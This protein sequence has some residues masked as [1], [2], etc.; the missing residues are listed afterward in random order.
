MP[1]PAASLDRR[2]IAAARKAATPAAIVG[3]AGVVTLLLGAFGVLERGD[4]WLYDLRMHGVPNRD[5]SDR[6]LPIPVDD[7]STDHLGRWP[8][9]RAVTA[10]LARDAAKDGA[11]AV[12]LDITYNDVT[13]PEQDREFVETIAGVGAAVAAVSA[14]E[15]SPNGAMMEGLSE[16][17][18]AALKAF[19]EKV[20]VEI[21]GAAEA[22]PDALIVRTISPPIAEFLERGPG[23]ALAS[24]TSDSDG[25]LRRYAL[26]RRDESPNSP[27]AKTRWIPSLSLAI[28]C[29]WYG[30]AP[31]ALR[32]EKGALILPGARA[33]GDAAPH[34]VRIPVDSAAAMRVNFATPGVIASRFVNFREMQR[35]LAA[36]DGR[37]RPKV[38]DKIL[39]VY[40]TFTGSGDFH[41][42]P[43]A[44]SYP[45]GLINAE[46]VNT[47]LGAHWVLVPPPWVL[48]LLGFAEAVALIAFAARWSS[49]RLSGAVLGLLFGL[50][51]FGF[52]LHRASSENSGAAW[53]L[54]L[55]P[56]LA[57]G[58]M[59]GVSI[60][61]W[62]TFL[63]DRERVDLMFTLR[64]LQN[65]AL[66]ERRA[67]DERPTTLRGSTGASSEATDV[68][69]RNV[70][71][72][73]FIES[74]RDIEKLEN[75]YIGKH[76]RLMNLID[77]GGMGLVF[78]AWDEALDRV[79]AIKVLTRYS[80]KL[81]KRFQTEAK[82]VGQLHHPNVVQV[83][84]VASEG[85]IPYIVMEY[86]HGNSLSQRIRDDGP[87]PYVAAIEV[88]LQVARGL[89]AA[90][91]RHIIHRDIKTSNI[92]MT[93][94]GTAK[95]IDFGIAKFF[96]NGDGEG[97][98]GEKEIVGT[99]D[100]MSPEQGSGK[101]VDHRSDIYSLGI[102]LF[103]V[104][105]GKLP[106]RAEDTVAVLL[107]QIKE[108]L[109]DIRASR[110]DVPPEIVRILTRMTEKRPD[111]R[112]QSCQELCVDLEAFLHVARAGMP[113]RA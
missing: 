61:L 85:D 78:R 39:F 94:D 68:L 90:H 22:F 16:R 51:V 32:A 43:V 79:V 93:P 82:A 70:E 40:L 92:L 17:K 89:D 63:E 111:D 96:K 19:E 57:L 7:D 97:L 107:K 83:F 3:V 9:K 37:A 34:D 113:R 49:Y 108:A 41:S 54:P 6:L 55:A 2:L 21:P 45:G 69:K 99:A 80:A 73:R 42:T 100:Y 24:S 11:R 76:Y 67:H 44:N 29:R 26:V 5:V 8:W 23:V 75:T 103:R 86:V 58:G 31:S 28:A 20:P 101:Q 74:L 95:V 56:F 13:D 77:E 84:A 105:T 15:S 91:L 88:I 4:Q 64:A 112:Y 36:T 47:I 53:M 109:P 18:K 104:L 81:L 48:W 60:V 102:T 66:K 98:T 65:Q 106:F 46:V 27:A 71:Y 12:L 35:G 25:R 87:L 14:L 59:G 52:A 33:P 62:K 1:P 110:P 50:L 10:Q 38:K 72:G 30:V